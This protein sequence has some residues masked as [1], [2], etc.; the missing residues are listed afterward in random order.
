MQSVLISVCSHNAPVRLHCLSKFLRSHRV[1]IKSFY[2][3]LTYMPQNILYI[4]IYIYVDRYTH[5][6]QWRI[7]WNIIQYVLIVGQTTQTHCASVW[8]KVVLYPKAWLCIDSMFSDY[9]NS[10]T[11]E[12]IMSIFHI[13][14]DDTHP[15]CPPR[16]CHVL[17]TSRSNVC[18][19][20]GLFPCASKVEWGCVHWYASPL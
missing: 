9:H 20:I 14:C 15:G 3:R 19:E 17:H 8:S 7:D 16:N 6:H 11:E 5:I 4:Y 1:N 18:A 2:K 12:Q 13:W 10:E